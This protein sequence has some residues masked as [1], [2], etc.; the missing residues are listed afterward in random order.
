[1]TDLTAT[2]DTGE[3]ISGLSPPSGVFGNRRFALKAVAVTTY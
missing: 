1:M 3:Q 2:C